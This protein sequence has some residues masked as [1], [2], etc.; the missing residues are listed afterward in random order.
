MGLDLEC[1]SGTV[2]MARTSDDTVWISLN[3]DEWLPVSREPEP[4]DYP[5]CVR[6]FDD[7]TLPSGARAIPIRYARRWLCIQGAPP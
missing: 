7:E 2:Y 5:A 6:M 1:E 4:G 3:G